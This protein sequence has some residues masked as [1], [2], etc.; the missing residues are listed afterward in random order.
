MNLEN[1]N[2]DELK[3]GIEKSL[4]NAKELSEEGDILFK[5]NRYSRAYCLYQLAAEEVGKSRLL[6][7]LIMNRGL[8][9]KIDYK[10][11]NRDFLH[12][13]TK[14]NSALNF[15]MI[16]LLL[17][18]SSENDKSAQERKET[19]LNSLQRIQYENDAN[20]LNNHK[21][22]SLYVGIKD[23]KFTEPKYVITK[24]MVINIRS[25]VLIRLKAGKSVLKELLNDIDNI[26]KLIKQADQT[27]SDEIGEKF[28][29]TFFKE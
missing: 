13:Q 17:M 7:A 8:G 24:E 22:N 27:K 23:G 9:E 26:I 25:N 19:F 10:E 29:D 5:V 21:N 6:F 14:S 11:V 20:I 2:N 4:E 18:Y 16:A 15:E 1:L 3:I 28:F 12:H